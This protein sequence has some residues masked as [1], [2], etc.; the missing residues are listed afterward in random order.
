MLIHRII[1][2]ST[3]IPINRRQRKI[4]PELNA[5]IHMTKIPPL[6]TLIL[7]VALDDRVTFRVS[8]MK[9]LRLQ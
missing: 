5:L 7:D 9:I 3:E 6:H 1:S 8:G 2:R 4:G